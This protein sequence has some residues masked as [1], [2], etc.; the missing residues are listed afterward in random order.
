MS[1]GIPTQVER[2]V[3]EAEKL[4]KEQQEA[5]NPKDEKTP[6]QIE[7]EAKEAEAKAAK[8]KEEADA[9]AAADAEAAKVKTPEKDFKH[10]YEVLQG[11]Y[12][13]EVPRLAEELRSLKDE[14][15]A[16]KAGQVK[17]EEKKKVGIVDLLGQDP[18]IESLKA[19]Y[20]DVYNAVTFINQKAVDM[21]EAKIATIEGKLEETHIVTE[22]TAKENFY[23]DVDTVKDWKVINKSQEFNDWLDERDPLT[24]FVRR[25]ILADAYGQMDSVRVK[26][27]FQEFQKTVPPVVKPTTSTVVEDKTVIGAPKGAGGKIPVDK[28]EQ[29][30]EYIKASDVQKFYRDSVRGIYKGREADEAKEEA[31]INKAIAENRVIPG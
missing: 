27:F 28:G 26:G 2:Q 18:N 19:E 12:N 9:K 29:K 3:A 6:E 20:P 22:K 11:K 25:E 4:E 7:A 1:T 16:I 14:L 24:G 23:N 10:E 8:E 21:L 17:V 30:I 13:A 15:A 5:L 31:R